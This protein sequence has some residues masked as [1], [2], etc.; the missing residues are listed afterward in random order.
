MSLEPENFNDEEIGSNNIFKR[1]IEDAIAEARPISCTEYSAFM[2]AIGPLVPG[3][4]VH[5]IPKLHFVNFSDS[6]KATGQAIEFIK[7]HPSL[8]IS[9]DTKKGVH[10]L[11]SYLMRQETF[12]ALQ[13]KCSGTT[14]S[15]FRSANLS[16]IAVRLAE[17]GN[18]DALHILVHRHCGEVV[19]GLKARNSDLVS[20]LVSVCPPVIENEGVMIRF[21][22]SV[23]MPNLIEL[24]G[25]AECL[26]KRARI[27][28]ESHPELA[29]LL[30]NSLESSPKSSEEFP[31]AIIKRYIRESE[32]GEIEAITA[33]VLEILNILIRANR[34]FGIPVSERFSFCGIETR[35]VQVLEEAAVNILESDLAFGKIDQYLKFVSAFDGID[36]DKLVGEKIGTVK[37]SMVNGYKRVRCS[38]S[39][40]PVL[41]ESEKA[42]DDS[43]TS[44]LE[45]LLILLSVLQSPAS[46]C[47]CM[48]S[49]L[50]AVHSLN[51]ARDQTNRFEALALEEIA[52]TEGGESFEILKSY[53]A[54]CEVQRILAQFDQYSFIKDRPDF[55]MNRENVL[56]VIADLSSGGF[57]DTVEL[58]SNFFPYTVDMD[59]CA[60]TRA[61]TLAWSYLSDHEMKDESFSEMTN[62]LSKYP[63]LCDQVVKMILSEP[64]SEASFTLIDSFS[65]SPYLRRD[66]ERL[67]V[68]FR[69][70]G[71]SLTRDSLLE[72]IDAGEWSR[73]EDF[74]CRVPECVESAGKF[75]RAKVV[76]DLIDYS[77]TNLSEL[78]GLW[79]KSVCKSQL[80]G[81]L[82]KLDPYAIPSEKLAETVLDILLPLQRKIASTHEESLNS[83]W[84]Q[85]S[86][87]LGSATEEDSNMCA[88]TDEILLIHL[89]TKKL[90]DKNAMDYSSLQVVFGIE[91][92]VSSFSFPAVRHSADFEREVVS[93]RYDEKSHNIKRKMAEWGAIFESFGILLDRDLLLSA[94]EDKNKRKKILNEYFPSLVVKSNFDMDILKK[95]GSD[96]GKSF[97][98]I[99]VKALEISFSTN[100]EAPR[101][102]MLQLLFKDENAELIAKL[103]TFV[104]P[105][106]RKNSDFSYLSKKV[107]DRFPTSP[108]WLRLSKICALVERLG[109]EIPIAGLLGKTPIRFVSE[110]LLKSIK[111]DPDHTNW[112]IELFR[113]VSDPKS[114]FDS[115]TEIASSFPLVV[116]EINVDAFLFAVK[117]CL[118]KD[119]ADLVLRRLLQAMP[120]SD[121]LLQVAFF[122]K[123]A[124][125]GI[126]DSDLKSL[127][128]RLIMKKHNLL[129]HHELPPKKL[130]EFIAYNLEHIPQG[131]HIIKDLAHLHSFEIG[132]L[133]KEIAK[134][135]IVEGF[136]DWLTCLGPENCETDTPILPTSGVKLVRKLS[137]I[138]NLSKPCNPDLIPVLLKL[139]FSS[140][141]LL[142]NKLC[143]FYVMFS[144]FGKTAIISVYNNSI[145]DLVEIQK[146]I[147]YITLLSERNRVLKPMEYKEFVALDKSLLVRNLLHTENIEILLIATQII[148]DYGILD[149]ELIEKIEERLKVFLGKAA[150]AIFNDMKE[151][152]TQNGTRYHVSKA[153]A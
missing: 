14:W 58:L 15:N 77:T 10:A 6:V 47:D 28:G 79:K 78:E 75:E 16:E 62:L 26:S 140:K 139:Y 134:K 144:M 93:S 34:E 125:S 106:L 21:I 33:P 99:L 71:L 56:S 55:L 127:Q 5:S 123:E 149:F 97:D 40:S 113:L 122:F 91:E 133:Q 35:R 120:L 61:S 64:V 20:G 131:G 73:I 94:P 124:Y 92:F 138:L 117:E 11:H 4:V 82:E 126:S 38:I 86:L 9:F 66:I 104:V 101:D 137:L 89:S 30:L 52:K 72:Q 109:N 88:Q 70:F 87:S 141:V 152:L 129:Q 102:S 54:V 22:E 8:P 69:D 112:S 80:V 49:L 151:N 41:Q 76:F 36:S 130:I 51:L 121:S 43:T 63:K 27:I 105:S 74:S 3:F 2:Q 45:T 142:V 12:V 57:L 103:Y 59:D 32:R 153:L 135:W 17:E 25:L 13:E 118:E 100:S 31:L 150:V 95:F 147:T 60:L 98:D 110:S 84:A 116:S 46:R 85:T 132:L 50:T 48:Y 65:T 108:E 53:M 39:E 145:S 19:D 44:S 146:N 136:G 96:F 68:L 128:T 1:G 114:L 81:L 29:L 23:I 42:Q 37:L 7:S 18:I 67:K 24:T 107:V 143:C 83:V 115:V 148:A 119:S 111:I 90:I